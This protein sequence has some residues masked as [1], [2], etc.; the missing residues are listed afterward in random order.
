MEKSI[1]KAMHEPKSRENRCKIEGKR[2]GKVKVK[3]V[4]GGLPMQG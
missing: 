4:K 3:Q 2:D 1:E